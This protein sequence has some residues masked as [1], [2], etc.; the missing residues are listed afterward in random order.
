MSHNSTGL[1]R[2]Y[3]ARPGQR[4]VP[5]FAGVGVQDL[6]WNRAAGRRLLWSL[7]E[8]RGVGRRVLYG[9]EP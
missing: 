2:R 8:F 4:P 9:V 7:T 6:Y 1:G 3:M 5:H